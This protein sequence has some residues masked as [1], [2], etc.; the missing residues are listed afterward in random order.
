MPQQIHI[1][2]AYSSLTNYPGIILELVLQNPCIFIFKNITLLISLKARPLHFKVQM[3][4]FGR[5]LTAKLV[6]INW[7]DVP[8]THQADR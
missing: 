6:N 7:K 8:H 2:A 1:T 3:N 5:W 4:K